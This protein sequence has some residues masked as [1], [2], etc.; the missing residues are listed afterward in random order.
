MT[1]LSDRRLR[2]PYGLAGGHPG[3][4][5]RNLLLHKGKATPIPAKARVQAAP[6][7]I[8]HIETPGAGGW[9]DPRKRSGPPKPG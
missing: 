9:G 8:L 1:L 2:A 6:G 5:G 7:D 3:K 4:P